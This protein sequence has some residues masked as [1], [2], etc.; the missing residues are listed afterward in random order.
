M[1]AK[2]W[3]P[4]VAVVLLAC[5]LPVVVRSNYVMQFLITMML[6]AYL[7]T[8]WNIIG[9]Y[10]GQMAQGNGVY[11]GIGAYIST[12][13]FM[14]EGVSPW[15]GMLIGGG[16]AVLLA[17]GVGALTFRLNGTYFA[18]STVALLHV[19]RMLVI[20]NER[21]LGY[22]TRGPIGLYIPWLGESL[23]NMQF[24]EK[25]GYFYIVL[26]LLVIGI[27]VSWTVKNT[28]TG[29]YLAA[30]N[31][32]QEAA[33]SLGVNVLK[34]KLR[35]Y[36]LSAFMMAVGG[37]FYAQF[38]SVVDP[39]RVLGYDLSVQIVLY[40]VIGGKGTL[41]GPVLAALTLAPLNDILRAAFGAR[42]S[43]LALLIYG[44]ITMLIVVFL[45]GGLWPFISGKAAERKRRRQSGLA[46]TDSRS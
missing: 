16:F 20:S 40:A 6:Y 36:C 44:L 4:A 19:V 32:N 12:V 37:T 7:A 23:R 2:K 27:L 45:P 34:M 28:R 39:T 1:K 17:L 43:G 46:K 42:V 26:G 38:I 5:L 24:V 25:T 8:S 11:F 35:A 13:L 14:Y 41:W 29:Y 18:L 15:V 30:I 31:T 3:M 21:I 9:G 10:A 33:S 22:E